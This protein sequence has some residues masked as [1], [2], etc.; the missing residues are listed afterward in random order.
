MI[1]LPTAGETWAWR[2]Y[3]SFALFQNFLMCIAS[4]VAIVFLSMLI[5]HLRYYSPASAPLE[6]N[7]TIQCNALLTADNVTCSRATEC[8]AGFKNP[9]NET[10]TYLPRPTSVTNCSSACYSNST[11]LTLCDGQGQCV[12]NTAA[13]YGTCEV[14]A[15]CD[16]TDK[17]PLNNDLVYNAARPSLWA[18]TGWYETFSCWFGQCISAVLDIFVGSNTWPIF[19]GPNN[20]TYNFTVLAGHNQCED[21]LDPT[22]VL[23][24]RQCLTSSRY[25]LASS[26]IVD[27]T[28]WAGGSYGNETLPFQLSVCVFR[29][30]C[31]RST[32]FEVEVKKKKRTAFDETPYKS[33]EQW[34]FLPVTGELASRSSAA[35]LASASN[36]LGT[37]NP[38]LRNAFWA[39]SHQ[40]VTEA[41]PKYLERVFAEAARK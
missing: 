5:H 1:R 20:V 15:D 36:P 30:S 10:C 38:Q 41:I 16:L 26:M 33:Q 2:N 7:V 11:G 17:F 23:E 21:Y 29:F 9:D 32:D 39:K 22:F 37:N 27:Y 13:C 28:L 18:Y 6:P 12:G 14:N 31:G 8:F 34:G 3:M 25:L 40:V 4:T 35:S 24:Y 19:R